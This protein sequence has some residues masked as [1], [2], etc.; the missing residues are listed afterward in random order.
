M[1]IDTIIIIHCTAYVIYCKLSNNMKRIM[2][3]KIDNAPSTTKYGHR[4]DHTLCI[5]NSY[6]IF[7]GWPLPIY[8]SVSTVWSI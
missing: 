6:N 3:L 8:L 2:L 4:G 1:L 5:T 7:N